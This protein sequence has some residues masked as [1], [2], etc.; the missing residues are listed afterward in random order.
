MVFLRRKHLSEPLLDWPKKAYISAHLPAY[1]PAGGSNLSAGRFTQFNAVRSSS[2]RQSN[3]HHSGVSK[4]S[5][6]T[7][8]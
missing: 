2:L 8:V 1:I 5:K 4:N 7:Q 6:I 3:L